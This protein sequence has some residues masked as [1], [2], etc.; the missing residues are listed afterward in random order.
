MCGCARNKCGGV[1]ICGMAMTGEMEHVLILN[2]WVPTIPINESVYTWYIQGGSCY[3]GS[4][5]AI[6]E[7]VSLLNDLFCNAGVFTW[8]KCFKAKLKKLLNGVIG[9]TCLIYSSLSWF[10]FAPLV[11]MA[12]ELHSQ[13]FPTLILNPVTTLEKSLWFVLCM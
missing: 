5:P 10:I 4:F 13:I 8:F 1:W 11:L 9:F 7:K 3:E 6:N 12:F 2:S